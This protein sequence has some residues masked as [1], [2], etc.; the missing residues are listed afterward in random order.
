MCELLLCEG[1]HN[2]EQ[3]FWIDGKQVFAKPGLTLAVGGSG[4][5]QRFMFQVFHGGK[6]KQFKPRKTQYQ[7]YAQT[8]PVLSFVLPPFH[9][10]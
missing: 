9:C 4:K 6:T 8:S 10:T 5:I 1:K 3:I 2:G 7:W